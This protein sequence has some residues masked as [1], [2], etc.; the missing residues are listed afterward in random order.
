MSER[1]SGRVR[2]TAV[3]LACV[4]ALG[5][6][7]C[8]TMQ[9]DKNR[10]AVGTIV[11]AT[12]GAALGYWGIGGSGAGKWFAAIVTGAAGGALG[13]AAMD[14]YNTMR[15]TDRA[16]M[17]RTVFRGLNDTES[18][19]EIQWQNEQTGNG[20]AVTPRR[21]YLDDKGRICRDFDSSASLDGV[22]HQGS[23]TAC[24]NGAGNWVLI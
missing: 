8:E 24:R 11:G 14:Y 21:T 15:K 6:G 19:R 22:D 13:Y 12:A 5:L 17:D 23:G 16:S 4:A 18:G 3:A 20:G 9:D 1:S 7:G 2:R 10:L